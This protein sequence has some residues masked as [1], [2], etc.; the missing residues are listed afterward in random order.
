[1]ANKKRNHKRK[2]LAEKI[3]TREMKKESESKTN[4]FEMKVNRK[5]MHVIGNKSRK[6]EKGFPGM[7]K[8]KDI[9]KRKSS[10]LQ[11]VIN[12]KK[13]NKFIDKRIG[14]Y[15]TEVS[16]QD[17]MIARFEVEH[18]KNKKK[19]GVLNSD[20]ELTHR[21]HTLASIEKFDGIV[22]DDDDEEEEKLNEEFVSKAHFGGLFLKRDPEESAKNRDEIIADLIAKSKERKEAKQTQREMSEIYTEKLDDLFKT[23]QS[24]LSL[25]KKDDEEEKKSLSSYDILVRELK[26]EARAQAT[27]PRKKAEEIARK[28]QIKKEKLDKQLRERMKMPN[29]ENKLHASIS[30]DALDDDFL[31]EE[32]NEDKE[33]DDTVEDIKDEEESE[34]VEDT[35]EAEMMESLLEFVKYCLKV[36][37][38][39]SPSQNLVT[40]EVVNDQLLLQKLETLNKIAVRSPSAFADCIIQ[41]MQL[42]RESFLKSTRRKSLNNNNVF[43]EIVF[44]FK[45]IQVLYS[46]SDFR[47]PVATTAMILMAEMLVLLDTNRFSHVTTGLYICSLFSEYTQ[48]SKRYIPECFGFLSSLMDSLSTKIVGTLTENNPQESQSSISIQNARY[49]LLNNCMTSIIKFLQAYHLSF[50]DKLLENFNMS[51]T[52]LMGSNV[53]LPTNVKDNLAALKTH[54]ESKSD[55]KIGKLIQDNSK[56]FNVKML[57]PRLKAATSKRLTQK[58][59]RRRD[60]REMKDSMREVRKDNKFLADEKI[61]DQIERDQIRKRKV[62]EL[63]QS[64]AE[65]SG[66]Y[67][68]L[69]RKKFKSEKS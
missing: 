17:K 51:V 62:K 15:D 54:L 10:L 13:S 28:E 24:R 60:R 49:L 69:A 50:Y 16:E 1:M 11:D 38:K 12:S 63:L 18:K 25:K 39:Q 7:S 3:A 8:L 55:F 29:A 30:A 20:V 42:N 61:K 37:D 67:K 2:D 68:S 22:S 33:D 45:L 64:V 35:N 31:V 53:I 14:E 26:F 57:T 19:I 52:L 48:L 44:L 23:V 58:H 65:E 27:D 6:F 40:N 59:E 56:R 9:E 47:H 4:P 21:G 41:T 43:K 32:K 34:E 66:Y 36:N 46:T 5:K